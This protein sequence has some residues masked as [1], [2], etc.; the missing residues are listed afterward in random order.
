MGQ[1]DA[2]TDGTRLKRAAVNYQ[3]SNGR[4]FRVDDDWIIGLPRGQTDRLGLPHL[5]QGEEGRNQKHAH[6]GQN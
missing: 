4:G 6:K 3:R 5:R 1:I 2:R